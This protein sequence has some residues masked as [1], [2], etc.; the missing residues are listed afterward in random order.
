[1]E[2]SKAMLAGIVT[3]TMIL[4]GAVIVETIEKTYYC[5]PEDSVRE[6][7]KLSGTN[8]TCYYIGTDGNL[9]DLCS[10]GK[11]Q[12]IENYVNFKTTPPTAII[13]VAKKEVDAIENAGQPVYPDLINYTITRIATSPESD[14]A[15]IEWEMYVDLTNPKRRGSP[16]GFT[17]PKSQ[18]L[19]DTFIEQELK[20]VVSQNFDSY[21]QSLKKSVIVDYPEHPLYN[22]KY[23][24]VE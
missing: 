3:L 19:N 12:P 2:L 13:D 8:A 22:K 9:S 17:I 7:Y 24:E 6:C 1:M 16:V 21:N 4:S 23:T 11:W 5:A 18:L 20:K 15:I 10:K 14:L